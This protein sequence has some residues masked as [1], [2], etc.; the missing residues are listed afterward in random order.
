MS[1][2]SENFKKKKVAIVVMQLL[3]PRTIW[4]SVFDYY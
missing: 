3:S 2:V 1:D 4:V